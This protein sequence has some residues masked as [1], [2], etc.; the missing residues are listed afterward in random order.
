MELKFLSGNKMFS[1][2]SNQTME[3]DDK[4]FALF[5]F[6]CIVVV[7]FQSIAG[8]VNE[9]SFTQVQL[10]EWYHLCFYRFEG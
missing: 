8:P 4:I 7:I 2:T 3:M 5:S 1:F 10:F 6:I 9:S